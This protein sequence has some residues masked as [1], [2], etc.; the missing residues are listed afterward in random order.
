LRPDLYLPPFQAKGDSATDAMNALEM[1]LRRMYPGQNAVALVEEK[2]VDS[3]ENIKGGIYR[4]YSVPSAFK[5]IKEDFVEVY[6]NDELSVF[7]RSQ[8]SGT[9]YVPLITQPISDG[10]AQKKRYDNDARHSLSMPPDS[11]N[12]RL[13]R[14]LMGSVP[15]RVTCFHSNPS[16]HPF[17]PRSHNITRN[18][19]CSPECFVS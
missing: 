8:G 19:I 17:P 12:Q 2:R 6:I 5:L 11:L 9:K 10:G 15:L 16:P 18:I 4:R 13:M 1:A 3:S 7:Y 14:T